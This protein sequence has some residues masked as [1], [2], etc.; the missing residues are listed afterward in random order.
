V[1]LRHLRRGEVR[2]ASHCFA[3][4]GFGFGDFEGR[5]MARFLCFAGE[6]LAEQFA[7]YAL[8]LDELDVLD[9]AGRICSS[10]PPSG[11]AM[12]AR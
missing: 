4:R 12:L 6:G 9:A 11:L 10:A 1:A 8:V 7:V 2:Q 3:R 5:Q